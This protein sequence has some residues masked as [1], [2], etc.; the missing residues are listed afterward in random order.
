LFELCYLT[1]KFS[2]CVLQSLYDALLSLL[3][4]YSF[5][6]FGKP[7][8]WFLSAKNLSQVLKKNII[9]VELNP[10]HGNRLNDLDIQSGLGTGTSFGWIHAVEL[11]EDGTQISLNLFVKLPTGDYL[12]AYS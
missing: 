4:P 5:N 1:I 8:V 2:Y 3:F 6:P 9:S 12:K 11:L 7:F 10:I